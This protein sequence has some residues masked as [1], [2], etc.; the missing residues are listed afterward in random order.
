M[1]A[2]PAKKPMPRHAP[3]I[4]RIV[5]SRP[6]LFL[7]ALLGLVV[8]GVLS[9]VTE[10]KPA[11][12][13]LIG[14][15]VGVA[16]YLILAFELMAHC[17]VHHIRRRAIQQDD[18]AV[19]ILV[20]TAI[21]ALASFGAIIAE[22]STVQGTTRTPA[23]LVIATATIVLSWVFTHMTFALHYAHE[24]YGEDAGK[25]AG[26]AF[27][28]K[29]EPDYWDFFYFSIV[30][31]MTSQVS[32]VAVTT[33]TIRRTVTAHGIVSFFFNAALLALTVNIAA[34]AI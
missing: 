10:W 14:W 18:G 25:D 17:D 2:A 29:G 4:V 15:D 8:I 32:D 1:K 7:S 13:L 19:A 20:L 21:A 31:G 6:R 23:Q 11:T 22:L 3:S 34:S 27:P 26:M 28:G 24:F 12:R 16:L 33:K 9:A 5:R 30:I